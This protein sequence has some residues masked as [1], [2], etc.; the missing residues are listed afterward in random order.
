MIVPLKYIE[1]VRQ[2]SNQFS[3]IGNERFYRKKDKLRQQFCV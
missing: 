2:S 3:K 1:L